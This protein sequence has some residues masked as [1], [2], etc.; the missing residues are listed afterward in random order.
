MQGAFDLIA[1]DFTV[2]EWCIFV[3][4]HIVEREK[5]ALEVDERDRIVPDFDVHHL[6]GAQVARLGDLMPL[7]ILS[8]ADLSQLLGKR[9]TIRPK[10]YSESSAGGTP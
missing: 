3:R 5:L 6:A 10:L 9:G 4:A 2:G 7:Q 1:D 8:H